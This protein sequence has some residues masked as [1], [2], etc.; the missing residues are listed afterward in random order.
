M[1]LHEYVSCNKN[2]VNLRKKLSDANNVKLIF[3][4]LNGQKLQP[5]LILKKKRKTDEKNNFPFYRIDCS[6]K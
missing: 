6:F 4:V 5:Q 1:R 3:I 2:N